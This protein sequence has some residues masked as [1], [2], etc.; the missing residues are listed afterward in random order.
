MK[1]EETDAEKSE[2]VGEPGK[3]KEDEE[4]QEGEEKANKFAKRSTDETVSSARDR[5]MARQMAR[6]ACKTYIEKEE[7]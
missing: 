3:T 1:K 4:K 7:D 6:S 2:A 5:Y